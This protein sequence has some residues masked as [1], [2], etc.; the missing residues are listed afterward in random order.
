MMSHRL[1]PTLGALILL[2]ILPALLL[3]TYSD[4]MEIRYA[5]QRLNEDA[6]RFARLAA[7]R[8]RT[9]IAVA[10]KILITISKVSEVR[11]LDADRCGDLLSEMA[12]QHFEFANLGAVDINGRVRCSAVSTDPKLNVGDR[13]YVRE[14]L[15]RNALSSGEFVIDPITK[16]A[17]L[18]YGYPIKE[19]DRVAG[20]AFVAIDLRS[21]N[22]FADQAFLPDGARLYLL[23]PTNVVIRVAPEQR[24][25]V[26]LSIQS[27]LPNL[28]RGSKGVFRLLNSAGDRVVVASQPVDSLVAVC[29]LPESALLAQAWKKAFADLAGSLLVALIGFRVAWAAAGR[30]VVRPIEV[31]VRATES[32]NAG[33]LDTRISGSSKG[34]LGVLNH[35]F[36]RMMDALRDRQEA[37]IRNQRAIEEQSLRL[38]ALHLLDREILAGTEPQHAIEAVLPHLKQF[39]DADRV[40]FVLL[41]GEAASLIWSDSDSTLGPATPGP[42]AVEE[43]AL[44]DRGRLEPWYLPDLSVEPDLPMALSKAR[45]RGVHSIL[46][47]PLVADATLIGWLNFSSLAKHAFPDS[48]RQVAAEIASQL[49][50]AVR[51][52]TLRETLGRERQWLQTIVRHLPEGVALLAAD[53]RILFANPSGRTALAALGHAA[54]APLREIRGR[55]MEA[56]KQASASGDWTEFVVDAPDRRDLDVFVTTV[57]ADAGQTVVVVRDTTAERDVRRQLS[58][59]ERL[60]AVGQMA[61]GIAHDFN[62]VLFAIMTNTEVL[63]RT[64]GASPTIIERARSII[65]M[66]RR[67]GEIIRRILD[68]SRKSISARKPL[69][70]GAFVEETLPLIRHGIPQSIRL[71]F[72]KPDEELTVLADPVRIEQVLTN[73]L[74]N[75]RDAKPKGGDIRVSL[76]RS[77]ATNVKTNQSDQWIALQVKDSGTGIPPEIQQHIFEPYFTTKA[78]DQGTGLGLAQ[79]L[80]IVHDH[81]GQIALESNPAGTTFT[82]LFPAISA[83]PL[84][85]A[86][87]EQT[88]LAFGSGEL[89]LLAEDEDDVRD[90]VRDALELLGYRVIAATNGVDA[91]QL[92]HDHASDIRVILTDAVMPHMGGVELLRTIR[93]HNPAVR[94]VLMSGTPD[95]VSE[96]LASNTPFLQK[97]VALPVLARAIHEVL[98]KS[99]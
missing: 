37:L 50:I 33:D 92:F 98:T 63:V 23:D 15:S 2:A 77:L 19:G 43:F 83:E 28:P 88:S 76:R 42:L 71:H 17:S 1:R 26:G 4:L 46:I 21:L 31:L 80:G 54:G 3:L 29:V 24:A 18:N 56:L 59:Q 73:L 58:R 74:V 99:A 30:R 85:G 5:D 34:E 14:A 39:I 94:A 65:E 13:R 61:S 6:L 67:G 70:I 44:V 25:L 49:A 40:S 64:E 87:A 53:G 90:A 69:D 32:V 93:G 22:D 55:T 57:G 36:N 96:E 41:D 82:I 45:D 86:T 68:F 72:E 7:L 38:S 48:G 79:V 91:L 81:G 97:P 47:V 60:A 10:E 52:T 66:T 35:A 8:Q 51:Q 62:N 89:I 84:A 9:L 20:V 27:L 95:A 11:S 78:P 75:A 16:N 12:R